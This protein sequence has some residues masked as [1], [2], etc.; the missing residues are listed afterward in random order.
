MRAQ[1]DAARPPPPPPP[2]RAPRSAA[3]PR[4]RKAPAGPRPLGQPVRKRTKKVTAAESD[5]AE[6][7]WVKK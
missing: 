7:W 3:E 5:N 2:P 6:A 1:I 4:E